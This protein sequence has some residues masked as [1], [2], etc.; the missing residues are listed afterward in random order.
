LCR[1][2]KQN[3]SLGKFIGLLGKFLSIASEAKWAG[4]TGSVH[5]KGIGGYVTLLVLC[6]E[7]LNPDDYSL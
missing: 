6:P 7:Q 4:L 5:T 3:I 2:A 1:L